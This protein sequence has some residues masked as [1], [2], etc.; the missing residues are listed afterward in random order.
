MKLI[1]TIILFSIFIQIGISQD[2][3]FKTRISL[4]NFGFDYTKYSDFSEP[5]RS[6]SIIP[7]MIEKENF[8]AGLYITPFIKEDYDAFGNYQYDKIFDSYLINFFTFDDF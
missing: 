2:S 5:H 6:I 7:I 8:E 1:K 4:F 3:E